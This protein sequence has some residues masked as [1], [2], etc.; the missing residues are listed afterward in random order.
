VAA[1]A[2]SAAAGTGVVAADTAA[3]DIT[4]RRT[5]DRTQRGGWLQ[6]GRPLRLSH[7]FV[8]PAAAGLGV[9][10]RLLAVLRQRPLWLDEAMLARPVVDRPLAALLT[11]PL[12]DAQV[13]PLG[14]LALQRLAVLA[15]GTSETALRAVPLLASLLAI[16]LGIAL[17]RRTVPARA[18]PLAVL[19]LAVAR[20]LVL[21]AAQAKPYASDVTVTLALTLAWVETRARGARPRDVAA[22]AAVGAIAVW[23]SVPAIL[24]LAGLLAATAVVDRDPAGRGVRRRLAVGALLWAP[25]GALATWAVWHRV[26]AGDRRYLHQFWSSGYWRWPAET[27]R[28]AVWPLVAPA[29]ALDRLL[30]VPPGLV[31]LALVIGGLLAARSE[32]RARAAAALLAGP[33]IACGVAALAGA[34]PF[35]DRLVLFLLP[36]AL[37]LVAAAVAW[38]A[39]ASPRAAALL[40]GA[41][42]VAQLVGAIAVP[43]HEDVRSLEY[44][45]EARRAPTDAVYVYYGAGA[46][47]AYYH[48]REGRTTAFDIGG[49]HRTAWRG[50]LREV[51]RYAGRPVWLVVAHSFDA[52]GIRE[53]SALTAYLGGRRRA[54]VTI[55]ADGGFARRYAAEDRSGVPADSAPVPS[56]AVTV[57]RPSA[58]SLPCRDPGGGDGASA[59]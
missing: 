2:P 36:G 9:A 38:V 37:L 58:A 44:A 46:A 3:A 25:S 31:W 53:D 47:Y 52:G 19:L 50:Y 57:R 43:V 59:G 48:A 4:D 27:L 21:Y 22:L 29:S 16:P 32:P 28:D 56:G 1:V 7:R 51:D 23:L 55:I 10:L 15:L 24:V 42:V 17:A 35:A 33:A 40:G 6:W 45:V 30:V 39:A 12:P 11:A 41:L 8:V 20:P 5:P 13:A 54:T 14:F 26:G 18:V 34:Y 49:C